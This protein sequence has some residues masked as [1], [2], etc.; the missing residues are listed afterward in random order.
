[1]FWL[2]LVVAGV[3]LATVTSAI[4]DAYRPQCH[5]LPTSNWMNDP[6]GPY[7]DASTGLFH[8]MYQY[9]TPRLWGHAV[10]S[11]LADW[12]IVDIAL[13]YDSAWYTEVPGQTPGVYSGSASQITTGTGTTEESTCVWLSVSTPTNDMVLLAYQA[14]QSDPLAQQWDWDPNNPVVFS[15]PNTT[16]PNSE[17]AYVGVV[18]PPGRD[19]TSAW[20]CGSS[21]NQYCLGYATQ[22]SEGCPCNN[23]S[24]FAV[25]SA[26]YTGPPAGS[27]GD[28]SAAVWSAWSFEGY[29]LQDSDGAVMWECPDFYQ[30]PNATTSTAGNSM[31]MLKYSIGPGPSYAQPWSDPGPRDY[32]V[33]GSYD[34]SNPAAGFTVDPAQYSQAMDRSK[35]VVWDSGSFYASKSFAYEDQRYVFGWLPE[36]RP[37]S[38]DGSPWGWAGVQ[39]LPRSV[40]PYASSDSSGSSNASLYIRTPP[41]ESVMQI[42]RNC[43]LDNATMSAPEVAGD[44]LGYASYGPLTLA[45]PGN[46]ISEGTLV[47]TVAL[48]D[49]DSMS[50]QLEIITNILV[51]VSGTDVSLNQEGLRVGVRVLSSPL[52]TATAATEYTEVGLQFRDGTGSSSS[53]GG[54]GVNSSSAV[55]FVDP[56]QSCSNPVAQVNRT[57]VSSAVV[58]VIESGSES[59]VSVPAGYTQIQ[60]RVIVDHSVIESFV[61]GGAQAITRRVYPATPGSSVNVLAF[62]DCSEVAVP[63]TTNCQAAFTD[64]STYMLR[65][66]TITSNTASASGGGSGSS[67]FP[68]WAITLLALL[69]AALFLLGLGLIW[70][71]IYPTDDSNYSH[72]SSKHEVITTAAASIGS[73]P[74]TAGYTA[75]DDDRGN[76]YSGNGYGS[77][78]HSSSNHSSVCSSRSATLVRTDDRESG[79]PDGLRDT[80]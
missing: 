66:V 60:L 54:G 7:Y 72:N 79:K 50:S 40:E 32:Y 3:Q 20:L 17:T 42:L 26:I 59:S 55:L 4:Y 43:S 61:D 31:W 70:R 62:V 48:T 18:P 65:S 22:Q 21:E 12:E 23:I 28:C 34:P 57:A 16:D 56:S 35:T 53:S 37:V 36:E 68:I 9:E 13:N 73:L 14:N 5:F 69:G 80:L 1:M 76:G 25:F 46:Q 15:I 33:T 2:A 63:S 41:L 8:L 27:E 44:C 71:R 24:G 19:P 67:E 51:P 78:D 39:S 64:L 38:D 52:G 77:K 49:S 75:S 58:T 29:V 10:S 30:L 11:N 45:L 47:T 74:L 6:N